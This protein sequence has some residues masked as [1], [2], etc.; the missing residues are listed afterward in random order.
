MDKGEWDGIR[1]SKFKGGLGIVQ[2]EYKSCTNFFTPDPAFKANTLENVKSKRHF[3]SK[4]SE[5]A[6]EWRPCLKIIKSASGVV[7]PLK[8]TALPCTT[9]MK[10]LRHVEKFS[11]NLN[12]KKHLKPSNYLSREKIYNLGEVSD[13][14]NLETWEKEVLNKKTIY[15]E[16]N[17]RQFRSILDNYRMN[18][19]AMTISSNKY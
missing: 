1:P 19:A 11:N 18:L 16:S 17:L 7:R 9:H 15:K 5:I 8:I 13:V 6:E 12:T 3:T 4:N 14:K 2:A 10:P